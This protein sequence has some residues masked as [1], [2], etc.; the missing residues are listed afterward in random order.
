MAVAEVTGDTHYGDA[1][2]RRALADK[3]IELIGPAPPASAPKGYFSKDVSE[4]DLVGVK[5]ALAP[6]PA[7]RALSP[8]VAPSVRAGAW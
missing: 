7:R 4:I 8:P 1:E 3:G 2:T 6:R 5:P